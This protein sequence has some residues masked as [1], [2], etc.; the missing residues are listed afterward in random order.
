MIGSSHGWSYSV[1]RLFTPPYFDHFRS[2]LRHDDANSCPIKSMA[3][4]AKFVPIGMASIVIEYEAHSMG[5]C[6]ELAIGER[7]VDG[8]VHRT[9]DNRSTS[10]IAIVSL[11]SST[12]EKERTKERNPLQRGHLYIGHQLD[13]RR[14]VMYRGGGYLGWCMGS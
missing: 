9:V 4:S 2:R 5:N 3:R 1:R 8:S 10:P 13:A 7:E 11:R 6:F 14:V 12:A